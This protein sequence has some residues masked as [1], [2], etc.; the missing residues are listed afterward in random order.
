MTR[1]ERRHRTE[2]VRR[3][4]RAVLRT[5]RRWPSRW[6]TPEEIVKQAAQLRDD[7]WMI[8]ANRELWKAR[9]CAYQPICKDAKVM[10]HRIERR[11]LKPRA[12]R[13]QLFPR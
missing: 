5:C 1:A 10:C 13:E 3:R 6:D 12:I 7:G 2:T 11:T 8:G 4:R 9:P